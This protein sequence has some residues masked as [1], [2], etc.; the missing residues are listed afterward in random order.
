[1][2]KTRGYFLRIAII[3]TMFCGF[4]YLMMPVAASFYH[5]NIP[6]GWVGYTAFGA[7]IMIISN[8][9]LLVR[10]WALAL[11]KETRDRYVESE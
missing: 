3:K 6:S 1:M 4:I 9:I 8:V 7:A 2:K 10:A 11:D 5:A